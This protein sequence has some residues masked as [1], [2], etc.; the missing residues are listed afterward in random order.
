MSEALPLVDASA[1]GLGTHLDDA[2][3]GRGCVFLTAGRAD[4]GK[5]LGP[6][7]HVL[8]R[9]AASRP[10]DVILVEADGARGRSL[11]APA[12]HEPVI[13]E[14]TGLV[15]PVAGLD[16]LGRQ[17]DETCV[18]RPAIVSRMHVS[19]VVTPA[20]IAALVT[21]D[22]GGLKNVPAAAAVRP[23]LTKA[24]GAR[25]PHAVAAATL[26]LAAAGG[27]IG[28]VVVSDVASSEFAFLER[29]PE[30]LA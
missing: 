9:L 2:L 4:D 13:P 27:R 23:L 11:K 10:D 25:R 19:D 3:A 5:F 18:H 12:D 21:S 17:V 1:G 15:V 24:E 28:R 14:S 29:K 16:A 6:K 30:G 20:L 22:R 8:D 26:I 7:P